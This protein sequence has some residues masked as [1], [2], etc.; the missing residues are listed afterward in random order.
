MKR[1][2]ARRRQNAFDHL[3]GAVEHAP[4]DIF[5]RRAMPQ[6]ADGVDDHHVERLAHGSLA[7]RAERKIDVIAEPRAEADV[8][9][10]PENS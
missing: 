2:G 4:C 5:E 10:C 9:A 8:P 6:T 1:F 3:Q 7:P